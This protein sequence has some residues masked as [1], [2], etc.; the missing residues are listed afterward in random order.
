MIGKY[1]YSCDA[2]N[3]R[4][5]R[6]VRKRRKGWRKSQL[7]ACC[8]LLSGGSPCHSPWSAGSCGRGGTCS[9]WAALE[10]GGAF[11]NSPVWL[12][13]KIHSA[14]QDSLSITISKIL[15]FFLKLILQSC[16]KVWTPPETWT[17]KRS[18]GPVLSLN[19]EDR[20]PEPY[21]CAELQEPLGVFVKG[22]KCSHLNMLALV[23]AQMTHLVNTVHPEQ[24]TDRF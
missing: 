11:E 6:R 20:V 3:W 14:G 10:S 9:L 12:R 21:C 24:C 17:V 19:T 8:V 7:P 4:R 15:G 22:T 13:L 2:G 23:W 18:C 16:V 5:E 1:V